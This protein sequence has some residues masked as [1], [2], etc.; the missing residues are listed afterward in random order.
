MPGFSMYAAW[1]PRH[2]ADAAHRWLRETLLASAA[3]EADTKLIDTPLRAP[4][5]LS[6]R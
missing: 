3:A 4:W 2:D 6:D 1:H 5:E